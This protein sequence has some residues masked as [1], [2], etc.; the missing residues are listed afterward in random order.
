MSQAETV[1]LD[2]KGMFLGSRAFGPREVAELC[3][4]ITDDFSYFRILKE[5]I[6]EL[7][8]R[9]DPSPATK[10]RLGVGCFLVGS[11]D[12]AVA[13]LSRADGGAMARYYLA[14][15]H[16]GLKQYQEAYQAFDDAAKAG[17]FKAE[18]LLGQVEVLREMGQTGDA[19]GLLDSMQGEDAESAEYWFQR[20]ATLGARRAE[21]EDII[22][23]YEKAVDADGQ[24]ARALFSLA[25]ETDRQG[26]D[27]EAIDLYERSAQQ[28]PPY[29]GTLVNLG[30]L[31]EDREQYERAAMCYRRVT[32]AWPDHPRARMYL[33]D[34]EASFNMLVDEQAERR[35]DRLNQILNKPVT[36]FELS[37]RSRNCLQ[38]MGVRHLGDLIRYTE[39]ELLSSKN[40]GETSLQEIREILASQGLRLGQGAAPEAPAP[41]R[42]PEPVVDAGT[43]SP[44]EQAV[45]NRRVE[46]LNLSVRARKCMVRLGIQTVGELI[47]HT[48]N[49]LLDCKNFGVTSLNEVREKLSVLGLKLRGE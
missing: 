48:E 4:A 14:R 28:F 3:Q 24:H 19:M 31:Y 7:E 47:R 37:V 45:L 11:Y 43:M 27:D 41:K 40:F 2:V 39:Q 15:S 1:Q 21:T 49:E 13:Y 30:L 46:D 22:A 12:D 16:C 6:E 35:S 26:F 32:I 18:C 34:A 25:M 38:K 33:K 29:L 5:A 44:D 20:G 10:V 9:P 17:Y 23:C 36:D 8:K 42:A